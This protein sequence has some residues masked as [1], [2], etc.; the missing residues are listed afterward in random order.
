MKTNKRWG[1]GARVDD[2]DTG[3]KILL[4]SAVDCFITK[5]IKSTTIEDIAKVANVTRRTVYRYFNGKSD[6]I[7]ALIDIERQ[8]MFS[9]VFDVAKLYDN[10]FPLMLQECIWFAASY[11][12]PEAGK[13]DLVSGANAAEASPH[14]DND[15]SDAYWRDL[16]KDPLDGYNERNGR[17]VNID[18][19][20]QIVGRLVL[21]YRQIPTT[22]ERF[23]AS[24][25]ALSL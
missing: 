20:I 9:K 4:K 21:S 19:L 15:E 18:D 13:L 8:R 6:I 3:K 7:A 24:L 14:I 10:N 22:K 11:K 17:N 12:P 23:K 5:G 2:L 1:N 16:L 25:L